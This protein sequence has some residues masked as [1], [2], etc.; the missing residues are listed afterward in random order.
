MAQ[1]TIDTPDGPV[2]IDGNLLREYVE[3]GFEILKEEAKQ[4]Q[5]FK[6]AIELQAETLKLKKGLLTKYV[7]A[8]FKA[9]TKEAR[10]LGTTF[11]Q[12]DAAVEEKLKIE[13]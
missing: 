13:N 6:E 11:E 12:L 3:E 8:A 4:K 9:K 7:K 1:V 5:L 2:Q 10:E